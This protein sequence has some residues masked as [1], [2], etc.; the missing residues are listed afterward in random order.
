[1]KSKNY[2]PAYRPNRS[3]IEVFRN[4][5]QIFKSGLASLKNNPQIAAYPYMG[6]LFIL[7]TF[8]TINTLVF[9]IWHHFSPGSIISVTNNAPRTLRVLLGLVSFSVFYT[10]LVTAYF[11]AATSAEVLAKLEDRKVSIMYGLQEVIKRFL[12][13][14]WFGLLAIFFFPVGIL[15]QRHKLRKFP[16][17][18][19]QVVGSSFALQLPQLAPQI[20]TK[21]SSLSE[22]VR[23]SI[24]TLGE[25]WK[26]SLLIRVC[27]F[28][29]FLIVG[30]LGFLPKLVEHYWFNG[31]TAHLVGWLVSVFVW[32]AGYVTIKVLGTLFTT[33]L[34][35]Q[36][37]H[38]K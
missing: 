29:A 30:S 8:P 12:R 18:I 28:A 6:F 36:V 20:M 10:A 24:S 27:M 38:E 14:S 3:F 34:Y 31:Q 33:T 37:T 23:N 26:E 11:T 13:V 1:M 32:S 5:G 7:V 19:V 4:T 17:G 25:A 2:Q 35:Y 22:T 9:S 21:S 16:V 15:S